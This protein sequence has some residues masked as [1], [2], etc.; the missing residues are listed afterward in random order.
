MVDGWASALR[1]EYTHA[2][3]HTRA[4]THTHTHTYAGTAIK[5]TTKAKL[6]KEYAGKCFLDPAAFPKRSMHS[7]HAASMNRSV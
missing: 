6:I 5:R 1:L 3:T 4:H 7:V 2:R